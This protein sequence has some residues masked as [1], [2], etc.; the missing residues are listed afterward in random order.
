MRLNLSN[1]QHKQVATLDIETTSGKAAD[2]ELVSIGIGYHTRGEPA[3]DADYD[4]IHRRGDDEGALVHRAMEKL[5]EYDAEG[6]VT[7]NGMEFDVPFI[8]DRM[9]LLGED[10]EPPEVLD[11]DRHVDLFQYRKEKADREYMKWP[12]LEESLESYGFPKP[13][14][15][16][17]GEELTN[18]LFGEELGPKYLETVDRDP[19]AADLLSEVMDHYL[20]TDLEANIALYYADIG[21]EFEPCLLGDERE[22]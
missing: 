2:G 14:T 3:E 1:S 12:S 10:F 8:E 6:L 19:G 15:V 20:L 17:R 18:T 22:F 11:S 4:A 5:D 13:K 16:W 7:Y 9:E 21:V